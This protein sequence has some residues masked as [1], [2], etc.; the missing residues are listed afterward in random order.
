MENKMVDED[1][2]MEMEC[3]ESITR[4]KNQKINIFRS[5]KHKLQKTVS[6]SVFI[7]YYL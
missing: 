3:E 7:V 6:S 4:M 5:F 1:E 2:Q